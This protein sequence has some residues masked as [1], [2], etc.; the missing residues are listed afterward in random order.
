[1]RLL[2]NVVAGRNPIGMYNRRSFEAQW[3]GSIGAFDY[4]LTGNL[5]QETGWRDLSP[6]KVEQLFGKVGYQTK[7]TDFDL[8][9]AWANTELT[10]NG[11]AELWGFFP[12]PMAPKVAQLDK[13]TAQEGKTYPLPELAG[14]PSAWAFAFWGGDFWIFLKRAGDNS[15]HVWHLVGSSGKVSEVVMNSNRTIV[16]AG[17]SICAPT[18]PTH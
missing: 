10:G 14:S 5:F 16:G 6:S 2:Q 4:F 12:D 13:M 9:Y 8:S 7:D 3:G 15:T 17:V 18:I 1:M 11:N